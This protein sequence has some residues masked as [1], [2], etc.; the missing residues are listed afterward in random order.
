MDS[1][2]FKKHVSDETS[3][4]T[5]TQKDVENLGNVL[6][7]KD[8]EIKQLKAKLVEAQQVNK[9]KKGDIRA[10]INRNGDVKRI[11]IGVDAFGRRVW[12]DANRL[13]DADIKNRESYLQSIKQQNSKKNN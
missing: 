5:K 10:E 4:D 7:S 8:E 11:C 2:S 9:L 1:Q 13:T 3:N 12:K 6:L